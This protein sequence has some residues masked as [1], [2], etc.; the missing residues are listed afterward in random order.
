MSEPSQP[1]ESGP[2]SSVPKGVKPVAP[3]TPDAAAATPPVPP[4]KL[5]P[6]EQMAAFEKDLKENDWGHQPC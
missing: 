2:E 1:P 3:A 5:T 6:E 4:N